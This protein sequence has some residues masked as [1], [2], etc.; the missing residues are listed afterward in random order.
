[1]SMGRKYASKPQP[2]TGLLLTLQMIYEHGEPYC[3]AVDWGKL[4]ICPPEP[5]GNTNS[6]H[7]V[8]KQEELTKEMMAFTLQSIF[9]ILQRVL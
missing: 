5:S 2:P 4:L 7:L 9:F 6:S 1:M 8:A 3:N